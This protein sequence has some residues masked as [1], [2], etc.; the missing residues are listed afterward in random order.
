MVLVEERR[1]ATSFTSP[2]TDEG[3]SVLLMLQATRE[4]EWINLPFGRVLKAVR[5]ADRTGAD[6]E[7]EQALRIF[8][9]A[10]TDLPFLFAR[11][12]INGL[13]IVTLT[14]L[15]AN[16]RMPLRKVV[17]SLSFPEARLRDD[18][19]GWLA[20]RV[21]RWADWGGLAYS[22]GADAL[23]QHLLALLAV[24]M[25]DRPEL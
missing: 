17:W 16:A 9:R 6:D 5:Q 23:S 11:E 4:P 7:R 1:G 12:T 21:N 2:L 14:G 20:D 15:D 25:Q 24:G 22:R 18:F 8:E 3:R 13:H 19:F 10:V